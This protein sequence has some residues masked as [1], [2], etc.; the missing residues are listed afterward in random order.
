MILDNWLAQRAETGPDRA[1]LIAGDVELTYAELEQEATR[2]ARRLAAR[3]VRGG[4]TV[5]LMHPAGVEYVVVL[6][7]LMKLG[8]VAQP[9]DPGL[10]PAELEAANSSSIKKFRST[11]MRSPGRPRSTRRTT[12]A[13]LGTTNSS[14]DSNTAGW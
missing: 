7:A 6:H 9:L 5:V 1:A 11:R 10:S 12:A 8:A 14:T 3:G 2:V 4:A 13:W